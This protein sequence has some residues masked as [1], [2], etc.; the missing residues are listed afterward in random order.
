MTGIE[1]QIDGNVVTKL[2]A[3][4]ALN[5]VDSGTHVAIG[6]LN[7][8]GWVDED[9]FLRARHHAYGEVQPPELNCMSFGA[10]TLKE[11]QQQA[12]IIALA[13]Q[14]RELADELYAED[15]VAPAAEPAERDETANQDDEVI[16]LAFQPDGNWE[17][18]DRK[19]SAAEAAELVGR[20][21]F[22]TETA[23]VDIV[24]SD[25]RNLIASY[26]VPRSGASL[27]AALTQ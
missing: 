3:A 24:A 17:C 22:A 11:M 25:H 6:E 18:G 9:V 15:E 1:I 5:Q 21:A 12:E 16:Y 7:D 27:A 23:D 26:G 8:R 13:A 14:I 2:Q 19:Y 4:R 10:A 20:M